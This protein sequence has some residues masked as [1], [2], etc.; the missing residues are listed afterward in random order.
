MAYYCRDCSYTGT[1]RS[2]SGGCP[3]CGSAN[4]GRRGATAETAR[5]AASS[6]L[7][8]LTLVLLWAWLIT[9]IYRKLNAA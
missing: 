3:A 6:P 7:K 8:L 2:E 4:F 9:E 1:R 5:S